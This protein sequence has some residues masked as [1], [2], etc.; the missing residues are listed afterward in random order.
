[1]K[2]D[3]DHAAYDE[4]QAAIHN[5]RPVNLEIGRQWIELERA[6]QANDDAAI[7]LEYPAPPR[8]EPPPFPEPLTL[9]T[10]KAW[11]KEA[12]RGVAAWDDLICR[13]RRAFPKQAGNRRQMAALRRM[14]DHTVQVKNA[15]ASHAAALAIL[16]QRV[17]GLMAAQEETRLARFKA[18]ADRA[19]AVYNNACKKEGQQ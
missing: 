7:D 4:E 3:P 10:A 6:K 17:S 5:K 16:L 9:A 15:H 2:K 1:M 19:M 11:R 14:V 18:K 13:M 12:H 8:Y